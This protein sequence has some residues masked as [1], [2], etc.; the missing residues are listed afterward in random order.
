[1]NTQKTF[2]DT[3]KERIKAYSPVKVAVDTSF[4][5]AKEKLLL[6]KLAEAGKIADEIFWQ[7]SAH[8]ARSVRDSLAKST[9]KDNEILK[10]YVRINYGPYDVIYGNERFIPGEP[11]VRPLGAGFYPIDMTKD[12]FEK[13]IAENPSL[14]SQFEDLYTVIVRENGK[15][16]AIPYSQYYSEIEALASKL[17]EASKYAEDKQLNAYLISRA[18]ALR[19]ND[20][21]E[22]DMKWMDVKSS[23]I[24][25][26]IGP[27]E[28]YQD[29]LFGY[30]ASFEAV[31]MVKDWKATK[32]FEMFKKHITYFEKNLPED[33]KFIRSNINEESQLNLVN[34]AYYG[35]DC[36]KGTKTIA[37][38]LPNDPKV[39][40][41]KGGK[42]SMYLN[43]MK[44]KFE[45]NLVP[46]A[47]IILDKDLIP[48]IDED[49]FIT[50]T[51]LHEVSHTLGRGY[52][53][54]NDKLEV[55]TAL[56]ERYSALEECKADILSMYNHLHL[57]NLKEFNDDM[58]KKAR[59]TYLAGL[60]RSIRFGTESAHAKANLIQFNYLREKGAI[61]VDKDG[62]YKL[63]E[64]KFWDAVKG[65]ANLILTI[66][67][68]GDYARAGEILSKYAKMTPELEQAI[69]TLQ[70]VPRDI[71]SSYLFE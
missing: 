9:G 60:F 36:Q 37:A 48:F 3:V 58:I 42:N 13:A 31:I 4:L 29:Q 12:E 1:M 5:S 25:I 62:K 8:D 35:G 65:L 14:K 18:K 57:L 44:A 23:N 46:I 10:Q 52:V 40:E 50:S 38:S 43:M 39:R 26:V 45:K 56:K 11:K 68:T 64:S 21:F 30:K 27:I 66:Q 6:A 54:G 19:T 67:A 61:V 22:S 51:T 32:Q 24:D 71:D 17:E 41:A 49:A 70:N 34:V 53:Y 63:D 2:I 55:R 33:P 47:N 7:Q 15:L 20:Y 69:K 16:K 59:V 28:T